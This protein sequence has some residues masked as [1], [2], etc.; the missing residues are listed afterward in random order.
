MEVMSNIFLLVTR[1]I[2]NICVEKV[3]TFRKGLICAEGVPKEVSNMD[4]GHANTA[5][6]S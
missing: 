2:I 6:T 5:T 4:V 3:Y 1:I